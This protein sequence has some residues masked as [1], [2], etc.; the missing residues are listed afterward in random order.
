MEVHASL[1]KME[2]SD[3]FIILRRKEAARNESTQGGEGS[4]VMGPLD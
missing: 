4:L 1:M 3:E 2:M